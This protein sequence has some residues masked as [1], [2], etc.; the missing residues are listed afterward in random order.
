MIWSMSARRWTAA[1]IAALLA[2]ITACS[3]TTSG[4]GVARQP[5]HTGSSTPATSSVSQTPTSASSSA[6]A[7][8]TVTLHPAP[9]T[10]IRTKTVTAGTTTYVIKVWFEVTDTTC[11]DHAYG[12][13]MIAFLTKHKCFGLKRILATTVVNG[14]DVGFNVA[15]LG[16]P[17]TPADPYGETVAFGQLVNKD[18][19]GNITDLLR[20]GYRL[21]SGP[22]S[23]PSPDAFKTVGQ[24]QGIE[25]YD[26]WYLS[27]PTPNNDP[28][29]IQ[30]A[31]QIFLQ[32]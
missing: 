8:P 6:S 27:G 3:S 23:V 13:P 18:G 2:T 19:T 5:L 25:V 28:A 30:M 12:A 31:Q 4:S 16:F 24:D 11:A 26:M 15:Q 29:L 22:T 9:A 17:G 14:Q 21:P 1:P 20:D 32:Y 10:P 7:T